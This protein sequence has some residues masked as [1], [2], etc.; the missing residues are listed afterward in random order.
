VVGNPSITHNVSG[1]TANTYGSTTQIPQITVNATGHVTAVSL[2]TINPI[3]L[4]YATVSSTTPVTT[5]STT[6]SNISGMT[7]TPLAGTYLVMWD[8]DTYTTRNGVDARGYF[9][10][11]IDGVGIATSLRENRSYITLLLGLIGTTVL[12][13]NGG[14]CMEI[15]TVNGSQTITMQFRS[16]AGAVT[17]GAQERRFITIRIG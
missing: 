16:D 7:F 10:M 17:T 11:A 2:Q 12:D 13:P 14:H 4:T 9:R 5:T 15:V 6:F 8:A 1:V 3:N